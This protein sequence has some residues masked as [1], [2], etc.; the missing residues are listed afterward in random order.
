MTADEPQRLTP[1]QRLHEVTMQALSRTPRDPES[2][3]TLA[4]NAKGD[5]QIEVTVRGADADLCSAKA[6]SIF[7]TLRGDYPHSSETNGGE[8]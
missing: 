5:V 2:Q 4:R 1:T 3:V 6:Q 8:S 7:D